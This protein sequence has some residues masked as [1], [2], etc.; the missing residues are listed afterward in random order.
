MLETPRPH[1]PG[2]AVAKDFDVGI[3]DRVSC[4]KQAAGFCLAAV[5][6]VGFFDR[7]LDELIGGALAL[8]LFFG[9]GILIIGRYRSDATPY[10]VTG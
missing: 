5:V 9:S 2:F 8:L 3:C 6:A 1:W 7:D 10:F 4:V